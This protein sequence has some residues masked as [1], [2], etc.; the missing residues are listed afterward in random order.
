VQTR[1]FVYFLVSVQS[2]DIIIESKHFSLSVLGAA[3]KL[4]FGTLSLVSAV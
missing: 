4:I 2:D 3:L 1:R